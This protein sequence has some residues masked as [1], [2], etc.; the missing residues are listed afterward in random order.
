M[1]Y[2]LWDF[3]TGNAVGEYE[4]EADAL[5]VVRENVRT[6]GP[7]VVQGI[8]LLAVHED[9]ESQVVAQGEALLQLI[10][11]RSATG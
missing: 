4:D 3:E 2:E 5:A 1:S 11:E 10:R 6:H 7:S 9:G 8:A